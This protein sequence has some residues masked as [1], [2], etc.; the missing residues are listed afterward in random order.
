[1]FIFGLAYVYNYAGMAASLAFGFA[2]IGW[3][4]IIVG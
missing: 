1:V 4:F 3:A 2:K